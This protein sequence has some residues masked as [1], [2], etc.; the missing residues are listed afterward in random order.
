MAHTPGP[1][2]V[3]GPP[4]NQIV[5]SDA[6]NRVC[7]MAHTDGED[8]ERDIATARL[9]AAA[10]DY[11]AARDSL[12]SAIEHG[13]EMHRAWLK[14]AIDA[15]FAAADAKATPQRATTSGES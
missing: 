5:W 1:W 10:P 8:D 7:F 2:Y 9:I 14:E 12:F 11:K 3:D 4:S 15:H 6:E 13:D